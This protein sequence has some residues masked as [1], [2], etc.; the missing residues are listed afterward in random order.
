MLGQVGSPALHFCPSSP[1]PVLG[2][3][4]TL[5]VTSWISLSRWE[6]RP[7]GDGW[8]GGLRYFQEGFL[9][10]SLLRTPHHQG[11]SSVTGSQGPC[12]SLSRAPTHTLLDLRLC[13]AGA[14]RP[15]VQS[16]LSQNRWQ[17]QAF[18][19]SRRMTGSEPSSSWH[20]SVQARLC[21]IIDPSVPPSEARGLRSGQQSPWSQA[22][23][24]AVSLSPPW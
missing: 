8:V 24:R 9:C 23:W 12:P 13:E 10:S 2:R 21:P 6:G 14:G 16:W 5:I 11:S 18:L 17:C 15:F 4:V 7:I 20:Q 22:G 1:G 3:G 19:G